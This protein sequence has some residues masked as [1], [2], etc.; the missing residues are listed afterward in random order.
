[1]DDFFL[2]FRSIKA[3]EIGEITSAII[4][5]ILLFFFFLNFYSGNT[6]IPD[7][8][9]PIFLG[10]F[11]YQISLLLIMSITEYTKS[12]VKGK[13]CHYCGGKLEIFR[14]KC[15]NPKCGREQ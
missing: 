11:V 4:G 15:K 8:L 10:Y 7:V 12:S 1:M 13:T 6:I 9:M 14:Y 2:I 3:R 5:L